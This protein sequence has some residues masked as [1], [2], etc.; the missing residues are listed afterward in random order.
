MTVVVDASRNRVSID[1]AANALQAAVLL[2]ARIEADQ[3]ELRAA[4][5]R[6]ARAL[7]ALAPRGIE[8]PR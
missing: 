6:A 1:N 7:T 5:D 2:V 4:L 3:R 8:E